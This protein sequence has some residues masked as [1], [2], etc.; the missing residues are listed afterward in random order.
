MKT[1]LQED[2]EACTKMQK[3]AEGMENLV[4]LGWLPPSFKIFLQ[5][6]RGFEHDF[7]P[8][9]PSKRLGWTKKV[10]HGVSLSKS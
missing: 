10:R 1:R 9:L 5:Y 6:G 2:V 3:D 8:P 7:G 4:G